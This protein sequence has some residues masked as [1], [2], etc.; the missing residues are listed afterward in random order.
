MARA[1]LCAKG[2][3]LKKKKD[4]FVYCEDCMFPTGT[5]LLPDLWRC[6]ETPKDRRKKNFV[7]RVSINDFTRCEEV[8]E[9]GKCLRFK[10]IGTA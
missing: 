10:L 4:T 1:R 7:K 3:Q 6:S 2:T 5:D 8:N 9:D